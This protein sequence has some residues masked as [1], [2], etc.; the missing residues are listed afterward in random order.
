M[1]RIRLQHLL[2][3]ESAEAERRNPR[4]KAA[5]A[6]ADHLFGRVPMTWMNKT[7]GTFPRYLGTAQGARITDIDGHEYI[8]F[9]LGDTG[10]MAGH[11]P[12][13]VAAAVQRRFAEQGGAT[14]MLPT[15]DAEWVGAELTR[16]FGL[17]HWSFSLTATDANRWAIRLAR[18]VTGRS[19]ILVNS[20]SYHGSVD[21]SLIVVGPDGR[22]ASRP[23]NVGAPC[24]VTLTS[25]VAEFN[26]LDQLERELAHGDVAAVL[27]EPALTNIGIVLPE[28]GYLAGVRDL[29][30]RHGVLL[31]N[32]E[33]HTFSAGPGGCTAAW[34]LEPDMLTIG[35]AIGGGIPAGAYGL[36]AELADRLL[37]RS[38]LDLVDMGGVGGTLAGNALSVAAMRATL[39]HVLTDDAF[40]R[41]GK[42]AERFEAGVQQAIDAHGLPWSV[43][44]LGARTEYRF[45]SPAPRTGTASADV[46]DPE[47][48]D[49]LHLYLAN[50]GILMTPFH[51]M[52]LMCPATT[53]ADVDAH[54]DVFSVALAQLDG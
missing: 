14:A 29:T 6:R 21:E 5:Y 1:D 51:N 24:D 42:L 50:R 41:M 32:D 52:A 45:A 36:S 7:A 40:E 9:C 17:S 48:E 22:G 37:G 19:K 11:S 27:M 44:R 20:Y 47:L 25:R 39:E 26:D 31:I 28:P 54:T 13:A 18:A 15:E 16:R 53:E 49:F 2:A 23:G 34:H 8:D 46:A 4:S 10:A 35:K 30:R 3:R 38:D 43:S 33:T 12:E